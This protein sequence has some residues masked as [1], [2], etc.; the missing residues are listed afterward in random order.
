MEMASLLIAAYCQRTGMSQGTLDAYLQVS[1][2]H[3]RAS[4]PGEPERHEVAGLL[5]EPAPDS[6]DR[7]ARSRHARGRR[8]AEEA[9]TPETDPQKSLTEACLHGLMAKL[10]DD[11]DA[12][13]NYLP[14]R[15][16]QNESGS[17]RSFVK[18]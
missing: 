5:G 14:P 7:C 6:D 17:V 18:P 12:L 11:V 1:K 9:L 10:C 4:G 8:R 15:I 3:S 2:R 13:D 16:A